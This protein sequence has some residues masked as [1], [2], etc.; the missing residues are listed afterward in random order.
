LG[1]PYAGT[2]VGLGLVYLEWSLDPFWR[3]G[4]RDKSLAA[5]RWLRSALVLAIAILFFLSRNLWVCLVAH[6][7]LELA[8]RRL[9]GERNRR[10]AADAMG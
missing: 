3:Q 7:L 5:A 6:G 2:F 1:D 9:G 4:W 10:I 8:L